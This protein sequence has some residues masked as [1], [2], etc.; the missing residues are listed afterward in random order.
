MP[1]AETTRIFECSADQA[2]RMTNEWGGALRWLH[3]NERADPARVREWARGH[4]GHATLWRGGDRGMG[5]F[6]PLP[7]AL[8]VLHRRLKSAFDPAGVMNPRRLYPDF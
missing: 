8:A 6:Q 7:E 2:I 3:A 5:V 1:K 4:G